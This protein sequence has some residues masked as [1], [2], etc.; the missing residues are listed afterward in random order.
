M[1]YKSDAQ[2][3]KMHAM[4]DRG[5]IAPSVVEEFDQASKGMNLP[6][7]KRHDKGPGHHFRAA[8]GKRGVSK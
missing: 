4:E 6:K 8:G 7:R 1:P 5:E 3:K 2:R